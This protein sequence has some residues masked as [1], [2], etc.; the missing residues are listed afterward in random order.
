M[1]ST[2]GLLGTFAAAALACVLAAQAAVAA[3]ARPGTDPGPRTVV[4]EWVG[5]YVC[6]QG[7]TGLT[8]SIA[9]ATPTSARA[10]F[11]FY[12]DPRN[13]KVPTG[14]FTMDGDY[15]PGTGR[16]RLR[17][18][19]W[20]LRPGGYRMV[21]FDGHVDAQGGRFSGKV[22]GAAA[23]KRF[24]LGR[25]PSPA[26]ARAECAIAMPVAQPG[27]VD[28][29]GIGA[30]LAADGRI[31]LD[32]LFDFGQATLRSDGIGQLDE[33]GRILLSPAL[34]QRRVGLH[35]H[36]DAVGRADANRALSGRRAQAVRDYLVT[37]FAFPPGRLEVRGH[38]EDRLKL[39]AAPEDPVN[40]RVEVLLLD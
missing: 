30:A 16:L 17:G 4:G 14:C 11:H 36:T 20:R 1:R 21:D 26:P 22:G 25:R 38:G 12:A 6:A 15:D 34:S 27:L 18:G 31:D 2:R 9:E 19:Q 28:A 13:P 33:L 29:G 23:C 8:L 40:R 3:G 10:L 37:R 32:I 24:D 39:P 5:T 35:G 7:L